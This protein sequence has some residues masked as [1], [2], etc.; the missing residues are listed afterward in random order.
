MER[1]AAFMPARGQALAEHPSSLE[2]QAERA[3][4]AEPP[5]WIHFTRGRVSVGS[6]RR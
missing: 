2:T 4:T 3:H 1:R 5:S 6:A